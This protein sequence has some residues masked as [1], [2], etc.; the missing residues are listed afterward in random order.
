MNFLYV[1]AFES[2]R[3]KDRQTDRQTRPELYTT[4]ASRMVIK[5]DTTRYDMQ[6]LKM[7]SN[8]N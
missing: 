1:E 5:Y 4:A 2:Y 6:V 8:A 3:L 7:R